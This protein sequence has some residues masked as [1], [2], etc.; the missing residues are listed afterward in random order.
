MAGPDFFDALGEI[1]EICPYSEGHYG[2][3]QI[4]NEELYLKTSKFESSDALLESARSFY[5]AK[6]Y[7]IIIRSSKPNKNMILQCSRGGSYRDALG[8]KDNRKKKTVSVLIGCPFR[9]EGKRSNG[10]W[11]FKL[12]NL[13]HNHE[14]ATD[15]SWNSSFRWF[16]SDEKQT[17]KEMTLAGIPPRQILASLRQQNPNLPAISRTIYNFKK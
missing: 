10:S 17:I 15:M 2:I 14:P 11:I 8:I 9:I 1:A 3:S 5:Y 4:E 7:E 12:H 13:N 6:G 16:S